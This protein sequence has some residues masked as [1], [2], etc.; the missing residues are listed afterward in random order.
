MPESSKALIR[1]F[2][3]FCIK[4]N[5]FT[6][7]NHFL[8]YYD[9]VVKITNGRSSSNT[10]Y[11]L[12]ISRFIDYN[13]MSNFAKSA[14]FY[15]I[16]AFMSGRSSTI[17]VRKTDDNNDLE[18]TLAELKGLIQVCSTLTPTI[19]FNINTRLLIY[20]VDLT[21]LKKSNVNLMA[22]RMDF[23]DCNICD[24]TNICRPTI[25]SPSSTQPQV[26]FANCTFENGWSSS[27]RS[28]NCR[29]EY[30]SN[31]SH[32]VDFSILSDMNVRKCAVYFN[33][34]PSAQVLWSTL[35]RNKSDS[36][37]IN[38]RGT[39]HSV[40]VMINELI[41]A[42]KKNN[43]NVE[44]SI[45]R[46]VD[47]PINLVSLLALETPLAMLDPRPSQLTNAM[48]IF[49]KYFFADYSSPLDCMM[50]FQ[51]ELIEMGLSQYAK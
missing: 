33:S 5:N 13:Q 6:K 3:D 10:D 36:I 26:C 4:L 30:D 35:P 44:I 15:D 46:P 9:F 29:F 42:M 24:C 41:S 14:V 40:A 19:T 27:Y 49:K 22:T 48:D 23:V 2:F 38:F 11:F 16:G 50:D 17:Y 51:E 8:K 18:M 12:P 7:S 34:K 25:S 31:T 39:D 1:R 32:P 45:S 37:D 28:T 47:G 20:N 43:I 21:V